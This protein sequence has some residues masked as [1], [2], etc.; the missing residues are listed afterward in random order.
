MTDCSLME[1]LCSLDVTLEVQ[2]Y[3]ESVGEYFGSSHQA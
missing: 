3:S 1:M 2:R